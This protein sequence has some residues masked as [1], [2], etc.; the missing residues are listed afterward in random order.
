MRNSLKYCIVIFLQIVVSQIV[1]GQNKL[2]KTIPILQKEE[3]ELR[4]FTHITEFGFLLGKQAPVSNVYPQYYAYDSKV[5]SSSYYPYPYYYGEDQYSNFTF[6]HYTGYN[7]HKAV[8]A[9]ISAGFDY[10][11][12]NII[13]PISI[14]LRT[15]LLPSR[16][17]SPIGNFDLGYGVLWKNNNDKIQK[18]EK[19]GGLMVNPSAGIRIKLGE[20]GSSLNINVG[21]KI[22][23]SKMINNIPDQNYFQTEFRNFNRL[24]LRLGVSF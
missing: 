23:K 2:P 13:T 6:Q 22:Q 8:N 12:A 11:R 9:G 18:I 15:T 17:I 7:F 16:R 14:G 19:E 10:Y 1:N 24:S 3:V 4:K 20:D 5:A 21:Y